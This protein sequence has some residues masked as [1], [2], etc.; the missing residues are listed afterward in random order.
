[1]KTIMPDLNAWLDFFKDRKTSKYRL[2]ML[3]AFQ[4]DRICTTGIIITQ[5]LGS[6]PLEHVEEVKNAITGVQVV[7]FDLNEYLFSGELAAF[8]T[9]RNIKGIPSSLIMHI[10]YCDLHEIDYLSEFYETKKEAVDSVIIDMLK[11]K[12]LYKFFKFEDS[13]GKVYLG[14]GYIDKERAAILEVDGLTLFQNS[15]CKMDYIH[16]NRRKYLDEVVSEENFMLNGY[17][18]NAA[19]VNEKFMQEYYS[20][21][22]VKPKTKTKKINKQRSSKK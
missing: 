3:E 9:D 14:S 15:C 10:R 6:M 19:V 11:Y 18:G 7:G 2:K 17:D 12:D 8:M 16:V 21:L 4:Y 1:M 5:L 13:K 22:K 20:K